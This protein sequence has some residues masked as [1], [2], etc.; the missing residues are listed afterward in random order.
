MTSAEMMV[1]YALAILLDDTQ[2]Y[3]KLFSRCHLDGCRRFFIAE[4]PKKQGQY[5]YRYCSPEH[6][7]DADKTK[8]A[9][10]VKRFRERQKESKR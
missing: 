5:R 7:K 9:E 4:K 8:V 10:R 6:Q 3:G 1:D 2:P